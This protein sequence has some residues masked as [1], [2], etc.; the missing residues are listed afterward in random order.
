MIW[1]SARQ[2]HSDGRGVSVYIPQNQSTLKNFYACVLLTWPSQDVKIY[3]P[4]KSDSWLRPWCQVKHNS[5]R[6]TLRWQAG[7]PWHTVSYYTSQ[8]WSSCRSSINPHPLH[9]AYIKDH[10]PLETLQNASI[11]NQNIVHILMCSMWMKRDNTPY[12]KMCKTNLFYQKFANF[13][14]ILIIFWQKDSLSLL[15]QNYQDWLKFDK[16]PTNTNMQFTWDAGVFVYPWS[17]FTVRSQYQP[18]TF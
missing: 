2:G 10:D 1:L 12:L 15:C 13:P 3:T 18:V 17:N 9:S 16:L 7:R 14:P 6:K 5:K 4:P 8:C 11:G